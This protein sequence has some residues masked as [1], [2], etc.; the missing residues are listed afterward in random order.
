[1]PRRSSRRRVRGPI[2][3]FEDALAG[4]RDGRPEGFAALHARVCAELVA[5]ARTRGVSDADAVVSECLVRAFARIDTFRGDERGFRAWC[6]SICRNLVIDDAR[7]R[8]RRPALVDG[9]DDRAEP[10][11]PDDPAARTLD[12]LAADDLLAE[13]D[14]LTVDQRDV[15]ALRI[16]ADLSIADVAAIVGKPESAVKALQHRGLRTLSR[17]M[18]T[19]AVSES[20]GA[21]LS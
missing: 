6:F 8:A 7:H 20:T 4:A 1:M 19:Q 17:R 18:S 13:L 12:N 14:R 15:V 2:R 11:A 16:I 5:F 10:V 3:S 9:G 21:T